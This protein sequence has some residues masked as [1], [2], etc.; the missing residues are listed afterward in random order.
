MGVLHIRTGP[1]AGGALG[2]RG[3]STLE[4]LD[5]RGSWDNQVE[6]LDE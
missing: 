4:M 1:A 5:L 2:N 6:M 3:S